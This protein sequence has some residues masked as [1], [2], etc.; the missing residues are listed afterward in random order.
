M[1]FLWPG[2]LV[3]LA[4]V[5][6]LIAA[7]VWRL[8]RRRPVAVRFSSLS[9]IRPALGRTSRVRRHLPFALFLGALASLV[10]AL[11]RPAAI[12]S[13][14]TSQVTILLSLDVSGSMCSTD[15]SP[16][17]LLAAEDAAASF[18]QR[19]ASSTQIGI[20]AFSGFAEVVQPPTNDQELLL[21]AV[22][23]LTTGRRTAIGSGILTSIDA[24]SEFDPSVAKSQ[25][26]GST[27]P[28]PPPVPKGAYA[29]D[30]VVLLTDGVSNAGPEPLEA[31]QQAADRG[32][33]VY[34][35]GFGSADGG[36]LNP[37]CASQF[38]G[39]EPFNG[40][41]GGGGPNG[42]FGGQGFGGGGG[43]GFRRG[44]DEDTLRKVADLTGGTY[45]PAESSGDLQKVF[46][47]LPTSLITKHE[48]AEVS[49]GF[50]G[51]GAVLALLAIFLAQ[52]WRPLPD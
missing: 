6:A 38:I 5:P 8:R 48:V 50:V 16:S 15:I 28:P 29:P 22:R 34:T 47:N 41:F 18:I 9:L 24:I 26:E 40:G 32:L 42:G 37:E 52:A 39:R 30:I 19:Q 51:S 23:S 25:P 27:E 44:I 10:V 17:R 1:Q 14:P 35:I 21:D 49:V 33:R 45:Y 11:A 43:G 46:E 4:I 20:V 31:A 2:F 7:Y 36:S 12:V 13:V 3:L